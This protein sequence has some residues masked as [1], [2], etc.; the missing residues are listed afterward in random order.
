MKPTDF[1]LATL[2][3]IPNHKILGRKRLQKLSML[4]Q[5]AGADLDAEFS[6]HHYGPFSSEL[7]EA[8]DDL[9]VDGLINEQR[10]SVGTYG[11]RQSE[12]SLSEPDEFE[13][14]LQ[15]PFDD[16]LLKLN[17][18][19]TIELEM[20]STIAFF[21]RENGNRK[22]AVAEASSI[23]PTKAIPPVLEKAEA[24]LETISEYH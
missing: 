2:E 20:A 16:L 17:E 8:A 10:R 11:M 14:K 9:F 15:Q 5:H 7:A 12:Y 19:T 22:K 1:I 18:F 3:A 4:L 6:L 23:K 21:E 24:I 13:E